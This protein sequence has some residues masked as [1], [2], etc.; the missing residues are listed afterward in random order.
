MT[1]QITAIAREPGFNCL[2]GSAWHVWQIKGKDWRDENP[3]ATLREAETAANQFAL[4][5]DSKSPIGRAARY[6]AFC[7]LAMTESAT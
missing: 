5:D 2:D 6:R 4:S 3:D 1:N 7:E